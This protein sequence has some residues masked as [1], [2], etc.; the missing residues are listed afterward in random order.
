MSLEREG[1][2]WRVEVEGLGAGR[3][4][5][6]R[7]HG[8][9]APAQG[10]RFNP[11]KVL[12]DP[13]ARAIAGDVHWCEEMYGY[14]DG[15]I[16]HFDTRDNAHAAPKSVLVDSSFD[17]EDVSPPGTPWS[18]TIVYELHVKGFT[19]RHPD[20]PEE[21]RGAYS[22]LAHPSVV[23][24]LKDLGVRAI[25]LLP[26]HH[27]VSDHRL[28]TLGLSNYWGTR[29]SAFSRPMRA[30]P[31]VAIKAGRSMSSRRW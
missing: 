29:R 21:L 22:G 25:E 7:V 11:H 20:L 14:R 6:F 18:E 15:D 23:E 3:P 28:Q 2:L 4:Y 9:Y 16:H 8:P 19:M 26:V 17:W 24:Y 27:R 5:G 30:F 12:L 13:Y 31:A 10:H 1:D